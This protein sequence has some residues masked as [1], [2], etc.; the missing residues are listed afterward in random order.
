MYRTIILLV[1]FY[2]CETWSLIL[3]QIRRLMLLENTILRRIYGPKGDEVIRESR[4]LHNE[5]LNDLYSSPNIVR[6]IQSRRM[7]W[8]RHV[9]LMGRGKAYTGFWWGNLRE[10]D[11]WGDP[12]EDWKII[13]RWIFR[14]WYVGVWTR[15]TWLR[16]GTVGRHLCMRQL[17]PTGSIKRGELLG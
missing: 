9:A 11:H 5:E 6:V 12:G 14:H 4:K 2:G 10:K 3:K 17:T 16:I 7:G 1:V 15:L 8:A 13:L